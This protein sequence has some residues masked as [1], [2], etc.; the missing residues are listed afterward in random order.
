MERG[1]KTQHADLVMVIDPANRMGLGR[2]IFAAPAAGITAELVTV[3]ALWGRGIISIALDETTA[4]RRGFSFM[5]GADGATSS[6]PCY[7]RTIEAS[8]CTGTGISA[9]DR[10]LTIRTAGAI[11][12]RPED[13][14]VPGHI[15]PYVVRGIRDPADKANLTLPELA[16]MHMLQTSAEPVTAWCDILDETGDV[17]SAAH[18]QKLAEQLGLAVYEKDEILTTARPRLV[19]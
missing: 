19:A 16:H 17:A 14:R 6:I 9:E 11:K 4:F 7:V 12:A 5:C 3:M 1:T 8:I 15:A 10:A 2:G 18:C 13:F